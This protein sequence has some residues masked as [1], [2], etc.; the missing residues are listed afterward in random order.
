M[1]T[2]PE[3]FRKQEAISFLK[4]RAAIEEEYGRSMQKLAQSM[5]EATEK[6]DLKEG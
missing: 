5:K 2:A 4:R 1:K 6:N 3:T